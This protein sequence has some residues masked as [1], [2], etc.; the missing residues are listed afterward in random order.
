MGKIFNIL[1]DQPI[2]FW[3]HANFEN[4]QLFCFLLVFFLLNSLRRKMVKR[5]LKLMCRIKYKLYILFL[6][7][8]LLWIFSWILL[9]V[10]YKKIMEN[11]V[12]KDD[13]LDY[14]WP[15]LDIPTVKFL[16]KLSIQGS[17]KVYNMLSIFQFLIMRLIV[18]IP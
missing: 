3:N 14:F 2:Y 10:S 8:F 17:F 16:F 6:I 5:L 1:T 11:T 9:F 15:L 18:V 4:R 7:F 13:I 12:Y